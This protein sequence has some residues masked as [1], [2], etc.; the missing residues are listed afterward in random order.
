MAYSS[1]VHDYARAMVNIG[2]PTQA[3]IHQVRFDVLA[4][5]PSK[6]VLMSLRLGAGWAIE[7]DDIERLRRPA[8]DVIWVAATR[9]KTQAVIGLGR[10]QMA[11]RRGVAFLSDFVVKQELTGRGI[12]SHFLK[13]IEQFCVASGVE[14]LAL[15]PGV[16]R[17]SFYQSRGFSPD[18]ALPHVLAKILPASGKARYRHG[19]T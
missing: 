15:I 1:G 19:A 11:P 2:E 4:S 7:S 5:P 17:M 6:K 16:S 10:L 8:P 9:D 18:P 12:G 13:H 14:R 3:S